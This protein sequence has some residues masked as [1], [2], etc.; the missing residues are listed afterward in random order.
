MGSNAGT[1]VLDKVKAHVAPLPDP[2][3]PTLL[4]ARLKESQHFRTPEESRFFFA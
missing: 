4:D 3:R 2:H 1:Q